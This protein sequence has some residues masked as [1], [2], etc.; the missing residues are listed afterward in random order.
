MEIIDLDKITLTDEENGRIS[1]DLAEVLVGSFSAYVFGYTTS[2]QFFSNLWGLVDKCATERKKRM[3]E[4][5]G[6]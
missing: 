3:K 5:E 1:D 6:S 4:M 2:E